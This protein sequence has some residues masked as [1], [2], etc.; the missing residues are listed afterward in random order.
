ESIT[1]V[2]IAQ[3]LKQE[4]QRVEKDEPLV[5]I[6]TDKVTVEVPAPVAGVVSRILKKQGEPASVGDVIGYMEEGAAEAKPDGAAAPAPKAPTPEPKHQTPATTPAPRP[7][8]PADQGPAR[9][10]PAAQRVMAQEGINADQ[11]KPTGP[12]GRIL[13]EDVQREAESR[14]AAAPAPQPAAPAPGVEAGAREEEAV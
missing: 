1:E 6:E 13:K 10:M 3:W 14:R 5:E 8:A 9:V 2:E 12:G 4:G 7:A 11:V